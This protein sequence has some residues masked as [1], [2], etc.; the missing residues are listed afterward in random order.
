M[1]LSWFYIQDLNLLLAL[2]LGCFQLLWS[3]VAAAVSKLRVRILESCACA[4]LEREAFLCTLLNAAL[5]GWSCTSFLLLE[6]SLT[7]SEPW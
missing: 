6:R 7:E 5:S 1:L 2:P 3:K 4:C